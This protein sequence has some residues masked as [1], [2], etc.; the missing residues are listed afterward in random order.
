MRR[1]GLVLT[2]LASMAAPTRARADLIY[3]AASDF[4]LSSNPNGVWSY[5]DSAT[6][7]GPLILYT[8]AQ[9]SSGIDLWGSSGPFTPPWVGHNGTASVVDIGSSVQFQPGQLGFHPGAGGE[10]SIVR[11]TAPMAGTFDLSA[12][13]SGLDFVGP[14]STGVHVLQNGNPIFNG[15]VNGFGP[16]SGPSIDTTLSLAA[17]DRLDFAVDFGSNGNFFNDSTGVSVTLSTSA[18]PEPPSTVMLGTGAISILWFMTRRRL[19][20]GSSSS[21][22]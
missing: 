15:L 2:V 7:G 18:V 6:P 9:S 21:P 11:F 4:S 13:F 17:G 16:G 3:D 20:E 19:A 10:F 22:G 12:S 5:G 14:T 8:V 1:L